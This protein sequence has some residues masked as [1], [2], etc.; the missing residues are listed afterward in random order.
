MPFRITTKNVLQF[1]WRR[2][3]VDSA[4]EKL[5]GKFLKNMICLR[6]FRWQH[7]QLDYSTGDTNEGK[8]KCFLFWLCCKRNGKRCSCATIELWMHLGG[9]L[10]TQ[11]ARVALGYA[12]RNCYASFVLSNLPGASIMM[13]ERYHF[14]NVHSKNSNHLL[15]QSRAI[16]ALDHSRLGLENKFFPNKITRSRPATTPLF[17]KVNWT[18]PKCNFMLRRPVVRHDSPWWQPIYTL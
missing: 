3:T 11:Q 16:M 5:K 7:D 10:S 2:R 1:T 6:A 8:W 14:L 17:Y 12:S 4:K 15:S 9:L 13:L 18:A